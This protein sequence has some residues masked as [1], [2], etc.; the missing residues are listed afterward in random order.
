MLPSTPPGAG[1]DRLKPAPEPVGADGHECIPERGSGVV[2]QDV[3]WS[4]L[5]LGRIE[6]RGR[7]AWVC[8]VGL[9]GK[10]LATGHAD[11]LGNGISAAEAVVT[12]G[13]R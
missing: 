8:Q 3:D 5:L 1:R 9:D 7:R 2:D 10:R 12:V 6:E 11:L 13:L 4:Q